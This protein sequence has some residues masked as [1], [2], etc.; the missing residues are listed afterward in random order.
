M[1]E[2]RVR[3]F[4]YFWNLQLQ[5]N[6]YHRQHGATDVVR[7]PWRGVLPQT[8]VAAISPDGSA[9]YL[10]THVYASVDPGKPADAGL[11]RFLHDVLNSFPGYD[12]LIK[13]RKPLNPP[14][15]S[16]RDCGKLIAT[17]PACSQP[18]RRT[19]EK[20][21]DTAVLT[22]LIQYA[23][24][25]N[26]DQAILISG[27]ADY[28]PVVEY[29]QRKTDKQIIQAFFRNCGTQLRNA[30]WSHVYLDDFMDKLL[31]PER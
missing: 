20:G 4:V 11:R 22:G 18:L 1:P 28:V 8:L 23:F 6:A 21:V 9:K 19:V 12:V 30:C 25:D 3:I 10:G 7:I 31:V 16:N 13:E 17:C 29:I 27:D 26:L 24:D 2:T 5:W 14:R 15:C